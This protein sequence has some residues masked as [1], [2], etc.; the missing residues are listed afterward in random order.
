LGKFNLAIDSKLRGCDVISLTVED[1][2]PNGVAIDRVTVRQK[3]TGHHA[4][5]ELT[6]QTG[7]AIR[8]Y[9]MAAHKKGGR[10]PVHKPTLPWPLSYDQYARSASGWTAGIGLDH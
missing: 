8:A 4:G 6:E 1:V 3:K 5:F 2:A 10:V 9:I 7:E